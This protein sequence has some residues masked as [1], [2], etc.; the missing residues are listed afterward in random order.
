M[1]LKL[2]HSYTLFIIKN[3]YTFFQL[4]S[5][6]YLIINQS[7]LFRMTMIMSQVYNILLRQRKRNCKLKNKFKISNE[8][9]I[10]KYA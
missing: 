3:I 6:G 9:L 4:L 7:N 8:S 1:I 5:A 10:L 2:F